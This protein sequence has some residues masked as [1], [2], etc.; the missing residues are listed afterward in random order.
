MVTGKHES[1]AAMFVV[2]TRPPGDRPFKAFSGRVD[3]EGYA[4]S[5][6]TNGAEKAVIYE[7]SDVEDARKA[8]AAVQMEDC[9][10][11]AIKQRQPTPKAAWDAHMVEY[12][13]DAGI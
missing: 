10:V 12:L 11:I 7:V 3:A 4:D 5:Q 1:K 6:I 9:T 8:V 13:R 2:H